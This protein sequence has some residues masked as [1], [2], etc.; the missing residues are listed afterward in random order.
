MNSRAVNP[1]SRKD[2]DAGLQRIKKLTRW[3]LAGALTGTGLFAGLAAHAGGV[4][5]ST[6]TKTVS[7]STVTSSGSKSTTSSSSASTGSSATAGTS[8]TTTP[9]TTTTVAPSSGSATIVSGA[10]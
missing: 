8:A 5:T 9:T 7:Q 3:S 4:T 6:A 1:R 2:R 10:S